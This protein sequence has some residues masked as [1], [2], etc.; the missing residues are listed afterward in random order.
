MVITKIKEKDLL[1]PINNKG[2]LQES[3]CNTI[4]HLLEHMGSAFKDLVLI[5]NS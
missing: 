5:V 1:L 4:H 3:V 2:V